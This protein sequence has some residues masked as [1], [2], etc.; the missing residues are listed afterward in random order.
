MLILSCVESAWGIW[1]F[2]NSLFDDFVSID[3]FVIEVKLDPYI[4]DG[5]CWQAECDGKDKAMAHSDLMS[6][7]LATV[8]WKLTLLGL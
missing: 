3:G 5:K 4:V 7:T 6:N 1:G 2:L 8:L